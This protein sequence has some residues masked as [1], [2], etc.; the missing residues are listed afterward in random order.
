LRE[1]ILLSLPM[2]LVCREDCAGIC[3]QCGQNRNSG[4]CECR[5]E[6]IDDRW[7]ALRDLQLKRT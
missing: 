6:K 4:H 1:H 7:S 2:H 5:D 3:P